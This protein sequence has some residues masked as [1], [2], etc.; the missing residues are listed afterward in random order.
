LDLAYEQGSD[1]SASG[2]LSLLVLENTFDYV[3]R[4]IQMVKRIT[5]RCVKVQEGSS[6]D[7]SDLMDELSADVAA[8]ANSATLAQSAT[9]IV[10]S[11]TGN[12]LKYLRQNSNASGLEYAPLDNKLKNSANDTTSN[13]LSSKLIA[14]SGIALVTNNSGYNETLSIVSNQPAYIPYSVNSGAVDSNGLANILSKVSNSSATL[15]ATTVPLVLTHANGAQETV[16]SDVTLSSMTKGSTSVTSCVGST[17]TATITTAAA[18]GLAVGDVVNISGATSS[19]YFNGSHVVTSVPS[20]TTFTYTMAGSYTGTDSAGTAIIYAAVY[21]VVKEYGST[22]TVTT[23]SVTESFTAPTSPNS[24]DYWLNIGVKPYVPYKYNGS[25]WVATQFVKLGE[26][27]ITNGTMA[28]PISCAFNGYYESP[29]YTH[30]NATTVALSHNIGSLDIAYRYMQQ[31][32]T[33]GVYDWT[34]VR[35][36]SSYNSLTMNSYGYGYTITGFKNTIS[37]VANTGGF[38]SQ[39]TLNNMKM[40]IKRNF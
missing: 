26:I 16:S 32:P 1:F 33:S 28:T 6:T 7:P 27:Q 9:G 12:A 4:L 35:P 40:I 24:G 15:L 3:T 18:H 25:S 17:T 37:I 34:F 2:S 20:S 13:Y 38:G 10:P 23:K 29:L 36:D 14:G 21:T 22:P 19:S 11:P 5:D 30:T 31:D 8:A 39:A